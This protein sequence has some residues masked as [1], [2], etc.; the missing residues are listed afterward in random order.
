MHNSPK[1]NIIYDIKPNWYFY[2]QLH[3]IKS[4][5]I[6]NSNNSKKIPSSTIYSQFNETCN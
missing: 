6:E 3:E 2:A 4:K 5:F 1:L